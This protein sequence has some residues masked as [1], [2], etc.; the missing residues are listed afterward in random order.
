MNA[1]RLFPACGTIALLLT[2]AT[3]AG[4]GGPA[5]PCGPASPGVAACPVA[6]IASNACPDGT[7]CPHGCLRHCRCCPRPIDVVI[8]LDTSGSMEG[9]I[10][11]ARAKLWDIINEYGK[12]RPQPRLRVGLLTYG[13]PHVSSADRGWVVVQSDLTTDLDGVYARLMSLTTS[14]GDEFVGWV[15]TDALAKMSWSSDPRAAKTIFVAGNESADQGVERYNFRYVAETARARRITINAIF[16]GDAAQGV[17]ERWQDVA[18]YGGG[19]YSAID[20]ATGLTQVSTP[21]DAEL[22]RLN[23]ALNETYLPFGVGGAVAQANQR[24]QDHNAEAFGDQTLASRTVAKAQAAYSNEHWDLVDAVAKD[25]GTLGEL[26]EADLPPSLRAVEPGER[27]ARVN[28]LRTRRDE[29]QSR[30]QEVGKKRDAFLQ[31]QRRQNANQPASF[32]D[33]VRVALRRQLQEQGFQF[34]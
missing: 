26:K 27:E 33:A 28:E 23:A 9:L 1:S 34:E 6:P 11:S 2:A 24:A 3:F 5:G 31:E 19:Y 32:D 22:S 21:F 25:A 13:S 30:I 15:L 12:A 4:H 17:R 29:V 7:Y 14:G 8:C 20:M 18:Q 16:A 10:N